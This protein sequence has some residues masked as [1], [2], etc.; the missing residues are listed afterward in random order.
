MEMH[1]YTVGNNVQTSK[2]SFHNE[3]KAHKKVQDNP[4]YSLWSFHAS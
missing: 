1:S 3:T 2:Q 4:L